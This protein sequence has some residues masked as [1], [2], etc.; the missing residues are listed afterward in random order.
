[1]SSIHSI[2]SISSDVINLQKGAPGD[3]MLEK[4][5]KLLQEAAQTSLVSGAILIDLQTE[6]VHVYIHILYTHYIYIQS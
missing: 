3:F 4:S 6:T 5:V 2:K 1:M